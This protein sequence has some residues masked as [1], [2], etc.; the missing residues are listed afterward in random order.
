MC[1]PE[2]SPRLFPQAHSDIFKASPADPRKRSEATPG[3]RKRVQEL[4]LYA[5][6][7]KSTRAS[8]NLGLNMT[9]SAEH[10]ELVNGKLAPAS[11][12]KRPAAILARI[13]IPTPCSHHGCACATRHRRDQGAATQLDKAHAIYEYVF[14][15][16]RYDKSAPVGTRGHALGL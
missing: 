2:G 16:M 9:S 15:T 14:R 13:C 5:E 1:P 8:T 7:K 6:E 12:R 10:V 4:L 11:A 3:T